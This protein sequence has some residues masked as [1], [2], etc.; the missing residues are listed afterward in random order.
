MATDQGSGLRAHA[1]YARHGHG[2]P[3]ESTTRYDEKDDAMSTDNNDTPGENDASQGN[4][5]A[6]RKRSAEQ[7]NI[8]APTPK[9]VR[10]KADGVDDD[11]EPPADDTQAA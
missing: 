3:T 2:R 9:D 10:A 7:R 6:A 1:A 8:T 5:T 4:R 11:A